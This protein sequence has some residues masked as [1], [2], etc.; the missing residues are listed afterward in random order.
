M[1]HRPDNNFHAWLKFSLGILFVNTALSGTCA[2]TPDPLLALFIQKGFVTQQEA[3]KVKAE[4]DAI[5]G[6]TNNGTASSLDGSKWKFG[7]GIKN[8]E[9]FGDLRLRYENRQAE[10]PLHNQ[11]QLDRLRY[12]VRLGLRGEVFD[13]YYYGL[14]LDTASNPR[15]AWV[16]FGS[17]SSGAPF[18]GPFGKSTG[19]INVGQ[20]YLGWHPWDWID[21]TAGKMSN[22]LYTTAMVWDP[23]L[24]P[25]G[26]AERSRF[27]VGEADFFATFG[28]FLYQDTNPTKASPGFF[29]FGGTKSSLPFLLAWQ[30]GVDYHFSKKLSAKVAPVIYSYTGRGANTSV[31][32]ATPDFTGTF[33][34]QGSTNGPASPGASGFP[35]GFYDGFTANQT[36]IN[37]LMVLEIPAEV[38]FKLDHLNLRLFGD[39]AQ[40]LLGA[41]RADAAFLGVSRAFVP[42][43]TGGIVPIPSP[44]RNDTKAWQI[45][46]AIGSQGGLGLVTGSVAKR[47]AWE[48]RAYW[49]HV[50]QYSL[51]PNLIDSDFFEGRENMEG[52]YTALSYGLT[53][54][55]VGTFRFGYADRINKKLGTGGSNQD[56]PQINPIHHFTVLQ[57]DLAFKF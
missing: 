31:N 9:L 37:D 47:H 38:N 46:L 24:N 14:R 50:E 1:H 32:S 48:A 5:R 16:T 33:V 22:P 2:E 40:N 23:D 12:A 8:V 51:D 13:G 44:Q 10:D 25:E 55:M 11:I 20:V 26:L 27:T 45:G 52:F 56:I 18:Q 3:E 15:S 36:G 21:I 53:E 43:N 19:G 39:Y 34:G 54:N 42:D 6:R 57:L 17:S 49:Q 28:Q 35:T 29:N 30:A 7:L 4:A 41:E